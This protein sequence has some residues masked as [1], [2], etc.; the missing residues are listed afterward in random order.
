MLSS[1]SIRVVECSEFRDLMLYACPE[2]KESD[3]A[4]RDKIHN[5]I[6]NASGDYIEILKKELGVCSSF[7]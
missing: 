6:V 1:Q 3:L 4:K 5:L 2:I 7:L